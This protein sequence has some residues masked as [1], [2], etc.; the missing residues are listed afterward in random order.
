MYVMGYLQYQAIAY[1]DITIH[2]NVICVRKS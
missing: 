1:V 2:V